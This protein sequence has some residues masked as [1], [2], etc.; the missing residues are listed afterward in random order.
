MVKRKSQRD[1]QPRSGFLFNGKLNNTPFE[2]D[3]F[4]YMSNFEGTIYLPGF[5][6]NHGIK[7]NAGYQFQDPVLYLFNS[8]FDF[9][10]GIEKFR[11]EKLTKIYANYVFP[12]AYPD[13]SLGPILYLKRLRGNVFFNYA[14]NKFR[15]LNNNSIYWANYNLVSYGV[16][17]L[18]DYHLLRMI[19]PL[20][21]GVRIGYENFSGQVFY[22]AVFGVDISG[23]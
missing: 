14:N 7:I 12:I 4:G 6:S 8:Q 20:S 13:L 19:F 17:I 2:K 1:I 3:L 10:Y 21:S 9:P 16:E 15:A 5:F 22:E 23:I 11:T 18:A